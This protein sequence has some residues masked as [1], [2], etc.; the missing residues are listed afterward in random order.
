MGH[1]MSELPLDP[2]AAKMVLSSP[3][4]NCSNEILTIVSMLSVPQVF[5]RPKEAA[6]RAD[7]AKAQVRQRRVE[8]REDVNRRISKK[9]RT[10]PH[11]FLPPSLLLLLFQFA[12]VDGDHLTLLNAYHAYKQHGG[13][14]DWCWENFINV[15]SMGSAENVRSQLERYVFSFAPSLPPS[16]P[17]SPFILTDVCGGLISGVPLLLP[18]PRHSP[19]FSPSLPPSLPPS[20]S[21]KNR[22]LTRME[23]PLVS[24]DFN[25]PDY[26]TRIKKALTAGRYEGGRE[27]GREGGSVC[28]CVCELSRLL[29]PDQEGSH[30]W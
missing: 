14:K 27:G 11:L 12:H 10:G 4:F 17:P 15:R 23:V 22:M 13:N 29:H 19:S 16:L 26:Y 30:C 21:P 6:K 25:S 28:D 18:F 5:M 3:D 20:L 8:R 1:K 24:P 9:R 7:E 2:Q